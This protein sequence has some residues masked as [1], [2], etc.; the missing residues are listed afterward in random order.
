MLDNLQFWKIKFKHQK[1]HFFGVNDLIFIGSFI[2]E[3][4]I[5]HISTRELYLDGL[6]TIFFINPFGEI[7]NDKKKF[8]NKNSIEFLEEI[9]DQFSEKDLFLAHEKYKLRIMQK[10]EIRNE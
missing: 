5:G 3:N 6:Q 4:P 10:I 1:N 2:R 8:G 7:H 9:T